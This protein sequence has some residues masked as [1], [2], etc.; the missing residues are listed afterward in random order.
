MKNIISIIILLLFTTCGT[1]ET[2]TPKQEIIENELDII[3]LTEAQSE[4][5]QIEF[6]TLESKNI[7][8]VIKLNGHIQVPPQ[9]LISVGMPL[10]GFLS[11]SKLMPGMR[12][13]KGERIA[14]MEDQQ[15]IHLQQE[16]LNTKLKLKYA[17][18]EFKRQKDLNQ[19][20]A[21]SD[22]IF[23]QTQMEFEQ[24]KVAL[25]ALIE[26]LK[27]I[28]V[29][30][31]SLTENNISKSIAIISPING[32][33]SKV[34]MNIG[35]YVNPT[36]IIFELI[37]PSDYHLVL[38]VFEKDMNKISIGQQII[39]Y[40]NFNPEKKYFGNI[41]LINKDITSDGASSILCNFQTKDKSL[42]HGMYMNADL[43]TSAKPAYIISEDAVVT[44]ESKN[45]LFVKLGKNQYQR[46]EALIGAQE[47]GMVEIMNHELFNKKNIVLKGAYTLLMKMENKLDE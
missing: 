12:V 31:A 3:D 32:Y 18:S 6:G 43:E 35:T 14:T 1:K 5:I 15:Y 36:D 2:N 34:N 41:L 30:P 8:S 13:S 40:N 24:L 19:S 42:M 11:H 37:N 39:A 17:E 10:G 22:K 21:T 45:Y 23:E 16:F 25:N 46:L 28:H 4:S 47:N 26:K 38:K 27:L 33:V 44:F 20:K 29:N 7:S 9:N